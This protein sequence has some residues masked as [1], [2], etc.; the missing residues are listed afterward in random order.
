M[1]KAKTITQQIEELQS[2]N[3]RLRELEKLF[4]KAVKSEFGCDRRS[5]HKMIKNEANSQSDFEK[6]ISTYF[7]LKTPADM[8]EFLSVFCS[9]S[10]KN[11]FNTHR[12]GNSPDGD[13]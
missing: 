6:K 13:R 3:D 2:E 10:S 11:F 8:E 4:E 12:A 7:N 5:I 9:E 1:S